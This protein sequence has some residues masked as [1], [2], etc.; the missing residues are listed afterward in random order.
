MHDFWGYDIQTLTFNTYPYAVL[1]SNCD[2]S[3]CY[4]CDT[5]KIYLSLWFSTFTFEKYQQ[6]YFLSLGCCKEKVKAFMSN[7]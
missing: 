3:T 7:I 1:G 2:V 6:K 4:V 5:G